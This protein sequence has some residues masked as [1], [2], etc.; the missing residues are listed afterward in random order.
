MR[1][2]NILTLSILAIAF[3]SCLQVNYLTDEKI[4]NSY[5]TYYLEAGENSILIDTLAKNIAYSKEVLIETLNEKGLTIVDD[6]ESA[7]L[8]VHANLIMIEHKNSTEYFDHYYSNWESQ[9]YD[10]SY[11]TDYLYKKGSLSIDFFDNK[12]KKLI[13]QGVAETEISDGYHFTK[14]QVKKIITK[15]LNNF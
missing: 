9:G 14:K 10:A 2:K 12:T 1:I 15:T 4:N 11:S 6:K 3:T 13:W 5:K 8:I 7:D